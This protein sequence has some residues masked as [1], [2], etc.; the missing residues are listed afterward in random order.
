MSLSKLFTISLLIYFLGA[1]V[2][3]RS[4]DDPSNITPPKPQCPDNKPLEITHQKL[5]CVGLELSH[6]A[7]IARA[8][9][10]QLSLA[11]QFGTISGTNGTFLQ[12]PEHY[13]VQHS[14]TFQF[15]EL[16]LPPSDFA[17]ILK[18]YY[19]GLITPG[20]SPAPSKSQPVSL[21]HMCPKSS[22]LQCIADSGGWW[23]RALSGVTGTFSLSERQRVVGGI[24]VPE[25]PFPADYD[26]TGQITFDPAKLF[27]TGSNWS[28]ALSVLAEMRVGDPTANKH[29]LKYWVADKNKNG[30]TLF[31]RCF[32]YSGDVVLGEAASN[33]KPLFASKDTHDCISAFGGSKGGWVGF[34]AA[35]V[36]KF[37]FK[38]SSQ[39]DF[40]KYAGILIQAP[41]GE[42]AVNSYTL[43]WDLTRLIAPTSAR[44]AVMDAMTQPSKVATAEKK[45]KSESSKLCVTVSHGQPSFLSVPSSFTDRACREFA[46]SL[47]NAGQYRLGCVLVNDVSLSP[48]VDVKAQSAMPPVNSCNWSV[49]SDTTIASAR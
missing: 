37:T 36:P 5:Q 29:E 43:S 47:D 19:G 17:K 21:D 1:S 48:L 18:A 14:L 8:F 39:F 38:R 26:R 33:V 30:L 49:T 7:R 12:A 34:L 31:D 27:I 4:Q 23:K 20:D 2:Q 40:V 32:G 24:V 42:R 11:E 16:F 6:R 10:Y 35:A 3:A 13:L 41:F 45:S 46:N 28:D 15:S 22:P 44:L 9:Q 25:G